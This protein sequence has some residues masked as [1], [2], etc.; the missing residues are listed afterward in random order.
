MGGYGSGGGRNACQMDEFHK[1][2]IADFE[3]CWFERGRSGRATW[4]RAGRETGSISYRL[5]FDYIELSYSVGPEHNKEAVR[6]RF[7]IAFTEQPFG[8]RRRWIVC[9]GC[10]RR[11]RVL[12]GGRHFRCRKCYHAT[13]PSQYETFRCRGLAKAEKARERVGANPGIANVWPD[14]PKGMHWRTYRR[15]EALNWDA[16]IGIERVLTGFL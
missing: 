6:E 4:S 9:L 2:D 15:L 3:S 8:G 16:V 11:C 12:I 7:N 14:K 1:L 13:Y 5:G 10:E